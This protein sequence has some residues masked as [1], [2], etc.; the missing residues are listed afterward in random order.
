MKK[1]SMGKSAVILAGSVLPA[2]YLTGMVVGQVYKHY[3][4]TGVDINS[5]LAYLRQILISSFAV[6]G[7]VAG[8]A[9]VATVMAHRQ[10]D[11]DNSRL[12]TILLLIQLGVFLILFTVRA[13]FPTP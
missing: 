11:R 5:G 1:N 4:T 10:G 12:A 3:N 6:W 7:V 9:F 2:A 13:A 8:L